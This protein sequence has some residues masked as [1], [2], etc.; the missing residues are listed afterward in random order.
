MRH[1]AESVF[2]RADLFGMTLRQW[3][4]R[5]FAACPGLHRR[6]GP[7]AVTAPARSARSQEEPPFVADF[8]PLRLPIKP[9]P[10]APKGKRKPT[11]RWTEPSCAT[12]DSNPR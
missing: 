4:G 3:P 5:L 1:R 2:E 10:R 11:V 12:T 7:M 9:R 8:P 6:R